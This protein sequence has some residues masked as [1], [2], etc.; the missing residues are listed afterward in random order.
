MSL[1]LFPSTHLHRWGLETTNGRCP[2]CH[3]HRFDV[4]IERAEYDRL[5]SGKGR[6]AFASG[7]CS[8]CSFSESYWIYSD[9]QVVTL[10]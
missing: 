9:G 4:V 10:V 2:R 6:T 7:H 8:R 1:R 5:R 3:V